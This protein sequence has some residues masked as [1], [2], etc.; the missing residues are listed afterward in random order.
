MVTLSIFLTGGMGAAVAAEP[1]QTDSTL[2][3][4]LSLPLKERLSCLKKSLHD[5]KVVAGVGLVGLFIAE[6]EWH[7]ETKSRFPELYKKSQELKKLSQEANAHKLKAEDFKDPEVGAKAAAAQKEL[8]K[9]IEKEFNLFYQPM[10]HSAQLVK[11]MSELAIVLNPVMESAS[12]VLNDTEL[13]ATFDKINSGLN[14]MDKSFAGLNVA[15]AQMNQGMDE[16]NEGVDQINRALDGMNKAIDLANQGMEE[17]NRG[18][19]GMNK[20]LDAL[21]ERLKTGGL[22]EDGRFFK[23]LDFSDI[24]DYLRGGPKEKEDK[25]KQALIS[26]IMNLLP[27]VGDAKGI[28]EALTGTDSVT[29]EKLSPADRALGAVILLRW[30]KAG[31][32]AIKAEDLVKAV[33]NEK[34]FNRVGSVRWGEGGG[35]KTVLGD[36]YKTPVTEDLKKMVN[37]GGGETNCRACVLAVDRT[38]DGAPTSALPDLGRGSYQALEKHFGKRFTNRSFSNIV[39]DIKEAGDG[40]RGI[41]YAADKDGGHVFNV[42]NRDGDVVFLDGQNGHANPTHPAYTSYKFLR[43]K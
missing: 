13:W 22:S 28:I 43:T 33:K 41:V 34:A 20:A 39:K 29:G 5:N 17:A 37:P 36:P 14:E 4:C 40:S 19:S 21:N 38:L 2:A 8:I 3:K 1:N 11:A 26:A 16:M 9:G 18:V 24:D 25:A 35:G 6:H 7:A 32:T 42:I 23:D 12:K 30:V 31:K 15:V 27:G 10:L